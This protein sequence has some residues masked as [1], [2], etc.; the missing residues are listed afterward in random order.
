MRGDA[1]DAIQAAAELPAGAPQLFARVARFCSLTACVYTFSVVLMFEYLS[2]SLCTFT[3]VDGS[4][5]AVPD[6]AGGQA[7]NAGWKPRPLV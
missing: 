7:K 2:S 5:T 1:N 4:E 6:A 3:S